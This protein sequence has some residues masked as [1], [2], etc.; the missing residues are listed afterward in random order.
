MQLAIADALSGFVASMI[1]SA[2]IVCWQRIPNSTKKPTTAMMFI[3]IPFA[4]CWAGMVGERASTRRRVCVWNGY[5]GTAATRVSSWAV[6]RCWITDAIPVY[7]V[8]LP[9]TV[10]SVDEITASRERKLQ[11]W[12]S[13]PV[14]SDND[15]FSLRIFFACVAIDAGY[16]PPISW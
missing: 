6:K 10:V 5:W 4:Y 12:R 11:R 15:F 2:R 3:I 9:S 16:P 13:R 1:A 14:R 8:W 7:S